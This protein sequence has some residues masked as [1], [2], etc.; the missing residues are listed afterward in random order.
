[1]NAVQRRVMMCSEQTLYS[2]FFVLCNQFMFVTNAGFF[3]EKIV[4]MED[5]IRILIDNDENT[6]A[7]ED[8][9]I[10]T[11]LCSLYT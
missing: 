6:S 7:I 9:N 2:P 11:I 4:K 1:M 5:I 10:I 3:S 8:G